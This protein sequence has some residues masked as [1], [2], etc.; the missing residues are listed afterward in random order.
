MLAYPLTEERFHQIVD[1][2][3]ERRAARGE[4]HPDAAA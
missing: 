1:E 3:A 2:V 4:S